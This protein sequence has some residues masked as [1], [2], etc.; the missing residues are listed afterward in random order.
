[1]PTHAVGSDLLKEYRRQ[2]G[3]DSL[4]AFSGGKDSLATALSICQHFNV[5]PFYY[6][7]VPGLPLVEEN[8]DYYERK[9]FKRRILRYPHYRFWDW[10]DTG[11]HQTMT[12]MEIIDASDFDKPARDFGQW[13]KMVHDGAIEQEKLD[14]RALTAVG[15]RESDSP[16]RRMAFKKHGAI[17]PSSQ[18]WFPVWNLL[19]DQVLDIIRKSGVSLPPDY[20]L[21]GRSFDGLTIEY[22]GPLKA[23]RPKDYEH[24]LKWY[25]LAEV[26]IWK[27]ERV[28][29]KIS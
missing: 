26:E 21:F 12:N 29:G 1:M 19:K 8:L 6:Y 18:A 2:H 27:Y 7:I 25:P 5:V 24:I 4:L 23:R 28:H 17:R 22:L 16:I 11:V 9:V 14:K 15:A 3:P 13:V 10:L 20:E